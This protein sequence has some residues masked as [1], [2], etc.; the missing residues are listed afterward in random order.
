M[1]FHR[2]LLPIL[3]S[4]TKLKIVSFLLK[5][6]AQ[7]SEREMARVLNVSHMSIN[8]TMDEL[9]A[10][11]FVHSSRI[12][13]AHVWK[14]NRSSYA[15]QLF[16]TILENYLSVGDPFTDLKKTILENIPL[17][18][19]Q[20]IVIFGS[21]SRKTERPDSDIDLFILVKDDSAMAELTPAL[22]ELDSLC[23]DRFGNLFSP[24]VLTPNQL[25]EKKRL[26]LIS[27]IEKGIILYE[28]T[29]KNDRA[30]KSLSRM[31]S[32]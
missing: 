23:L 31:P 18:S 17:K 27:E 4:P 10:L 15:F 6:E 26:K 1:L 22:E 21:I 11:S 32:D 16:S 8:R 14:T 2:S 30:R 20:K 13:R 29:E 25:Q 28:Y 12:G 3:N 19:V 9:A 24:Y 7:M 5:N